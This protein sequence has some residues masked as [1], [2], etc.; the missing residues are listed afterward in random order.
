LCSQL[1]DYRDEFTFF[2]RRKMSD[3]LLVHRAY[4]VVTI[5]VALLAALAIVG[6]ALA[7]QVTIDSFD[8]GA[9]QA[10]TITIPDDD[11]DEI[12]DLPQTANSRRTS[13]ASLGGER[14]LIVNVL[15]GNIDDQARWRAQTT[16]GFYLTLSQDPNVSSL[17]SVQWDG[18]ADATPDVLDCTV[19][20][21]G[22]NLVDGTNDGIV[23]RLEFSDL[24]PNMRLRA[25]TD[26]SNWAERLVTLPTVASGNV[27]DIFLPF[28]S[29]AGGAGTVNF[30]SIRAL[31]LQLDSTSDVGADVQI[32]VIRATSLKEFGDLPTTS[33]LAYTAAISNAYHIP[34]GLRL[35]ANVDAEPEHQPSVTAT[36]DNTAGTP[37]DEEGV[38]R[39]M[40]NYWQPGNTVGVSVTVNGCIGTCYFNGWI[41]WN[42]DGD[43]SD[44][45][46]QVFANNA[47]GNG[48][49]LARSVT[50]PSSGYTQGDDL[51]ARFRICPT[52]GG[53]DAPDDTDTG[54][55]NGEIEDYFWEFDTPN[56]V[57]LNSL[58]A[59]ASTAP[60][61]PV[62][63]LGGTALVTL[64]V[65]F[66]ARRRKL[67]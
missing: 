41:D 60:I 11:G 14:D 44:A 63:L 37:N 55:L 22:V 30:T 38:R 19:G 51:Y 17:A 12:P 46:E 32:K 16:T 9:S 33:P 8:A 24:T 50:V 7:A 2:R 10:L 61:V 57:T 40:S 34:Q 58:Q 49:D 52:S 3:K 53:C 25:Y 67:A 6:V 42:R 65:L 4:R 35:G 13:A 66:F 29:F 15:T 27:V 45:N 28:S 26:C 59:E 20:L 21:N 36:G 31:E 64:G 5:V 43:L 48:V 62:A 47:I 18:T 56:A 1:T 54:V 39:N 23:V